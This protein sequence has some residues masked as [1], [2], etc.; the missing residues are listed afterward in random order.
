MIMSSETELLL[1]IFSIRKIDKKLTRQSL[2]VCYQNNTVFQ[3][4]FKQ[5]N[6]NTQVT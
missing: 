2:H 6:V 3:L 1:K 5:A 4:T